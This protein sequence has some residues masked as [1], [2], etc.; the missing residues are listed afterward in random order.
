MNGLTEIVSA[1]LGRFDGHQTEVVSV[2]FNSDGQLL[3]SGSVNGTIRF[4]DPKSGRELK[5]MRARPADEGGVTFFLD[6]E[7][8]ASGALEEE[9]GRLSLKLWKVQTGNPLPTTFGGDDLRKVL[10]FSPDGRLLAAVHGTNQSSAFKLWEVSTGKDVLQVDIDSPDVPMLAFNSDGT[11]LALAGQDGQIDL[12][13]IHRNAVPQLSKVLRTNQEAITSIAFSPKGALLATGDPD[14]TVLL[15]QVDSGKPYAELKG[16]EGGVSSLVFG[17]RG[18]SLAAAGQK[19]VRLWDLSLGI[20]RKVFPASAVRDMAYSPDGSLSKSGIDRVFMSPAQASR[21]F[22]DLSG[23]L[24]N[25]DLLTEF[26]PSRFLPGGIASIA[27][28]FLSDTPAKIVLV[29]VTFQEAEGVYCIDSAFFPPAVEWLTADFDGNNILPAVVGGSGDLSVGG[30]SSTAFCVT[31]IPSCCETPGDAN[32]SGGMNIA[33][34]TFLIQRIN[35]GA[36]SAPACP[37]EADANGDGRVNIADI[38]YLIRRIF[39][40]GPA[41][42]CGAN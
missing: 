24:L 10:A 38:T 13:N 39:M 1:P 12:W 7:L 8:F 19:T 25:L 29:E 6:G 22:W 26:L 28:G 18:R 42:V 34:V 9:S 4:W 36:G 16:H 27:G 30:S 3:A 40:A 15:W 14:G 37:Q 11:Q 33:D 23:G 5:T 35:A 41:P 31:V 17:P 20:L 2:A 32:S 21:Q